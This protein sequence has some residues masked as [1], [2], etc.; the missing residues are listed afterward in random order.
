MIDTLGF[1]F[2]PYNQCII[3]KTINGLQ[4]TIIRHINK[5]KVF[6]QDP[7]VI[8]DVVMGLNSKF[9]NKKPV[10]VSYRNIHEYLGMKLDFFTQEVVIISMAD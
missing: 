10:I 3:N 1:I 8:K 5:L 6:Y 7:N 2:N 4:C 9:G